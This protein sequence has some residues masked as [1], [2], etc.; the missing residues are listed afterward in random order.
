MDDDFD[1][2]TDELVEVFRNGEILVDY[3]F[4]EVRE[5]AKITI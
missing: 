4:E 5:R 1:S 3:T 2:V